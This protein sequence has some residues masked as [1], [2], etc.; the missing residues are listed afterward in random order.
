MAAYRIRSATLDDADVLV[1]HRTRMFADMGVSMDAAAVEQAFRRWLDS[2]ITSA[3]YRAWLIETDAGE[4]VAGGGITVLPWP[5]GPRDLGDRLA[6]AYNVYTEPAHRRRGL[7]RMIMDA[8]HAWCREAGVGSIGLHASR[9]GRPLY[10][11]LGY[12]ES[13]TPTMYLTLTP[14][15]DRNEQV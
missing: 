3:L 14:V 1:H 13:P 9:G 7:A 6:F 10:E 15:P 8:I 2:S 12:R 5:P 4:V 11:S